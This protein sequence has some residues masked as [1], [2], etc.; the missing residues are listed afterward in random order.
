VLTALTPQASLDANVSLH[1]RVTEIVGMGPLYY[2]VDIIIARNN[3]KGPVGHYLYPAH[4][5]NI[6]EWSID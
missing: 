1:K 5:W 4:S 3:V 2:P 6:Y